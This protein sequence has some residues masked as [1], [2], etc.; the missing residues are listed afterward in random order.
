MRLLASFRQKSRHERRLL[1]RAALI[2][3]AIRLALVVLPF[4]IVCR[5]AATK[6]AAAP[7]RAARSGMERP[8]SAGTDRAERDRIVQAVHSAT[9]YIQGRRRCLLRGLAVQWMLHRAG[10]PVE[11]KIGAARTADGELVAHAWVER[12]GHVVTGGKDAPRIYRSFQPVSRS[13]WAA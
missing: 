5:W 13:T 12:D 9:R 6:R 2:S 1:V 10:H 8:A 4:R 3:M 11:L 7:R